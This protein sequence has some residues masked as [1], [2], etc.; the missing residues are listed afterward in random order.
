M[1]YLRYQNNKYMS[2]MFKPSVIAKHFPS[3]VFYVSLMFII[4]KASRAARKGTYNDDD[5]LKSSNEVLEALEKIG[6]RVEVSGIENIKGVEGPLIIVG[7]HMSMM[8]TLLLPAI[9]GPIK[10]VTFVVKESLLDYPVFKYIMRSRNPIA[11]TRTNPRQ[12]LKTILTEGVDRLKKSVS[13]IVFPQ[14]TRAHRFDPA[15]MS[16]IGVKLARKAGVTVVPLALKT[17]CWENGKRFKDFGRLNVRKTAY[18]A[19]GRPLIISGKGDV[20]Q[21]HINTFICSKL[22]EWEPSKNK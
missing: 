10:E 2:P 3:F 16:S 18:F 17:D 21:E 14:T 15:Q 11:L 19:F 6:V 13:I 5:W 7:N 20:E 8:E 1:Q 22:A 12:D 4:L 9:V